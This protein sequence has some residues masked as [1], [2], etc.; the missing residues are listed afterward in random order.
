M[1]RGVQSS[2]LWVQTQLSDAGRN[3]VAS[4]KEKLWCHNSVGESCYITWGLMSGIQRRCISTSFGIRDT[5][6]GAAPGASRPLD[7]QETCPSMSQGKDP[8]CA[9]RTCEAQEPAQG[10]PPIRLVRTGVRFGRPA[11]RGRRGA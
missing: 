8:M 6:L 5:N 3:K 4:W 11:P 2:V 7:L 10:A 1:P 9:N